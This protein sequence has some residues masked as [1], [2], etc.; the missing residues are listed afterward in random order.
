MAFA[1]VRTDRPR[2]TRGEPRLYARGA[3]DNKGQWF[4]HLCAV[5]ALR[6]TTG[7]PTDVTLLIEGEEES[8]SEYLEWLVR[9]RREELDT[10]LAFVADGPIDPSGRPHVLLGSRGLLYVDIEATGANRDLHSGNF[11][12]PVPN[13]ASAI[14]ELL[15]S[16]R[17]EDGRIALEGFTT[18]C[19]H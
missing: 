6:E 2:R 17:D 3:V 8:G 16:L 9:E 4:A 7:L 10:D 1:A 5:R 11:G 12:G 13:P 15:A 19:V 18:T 14:V